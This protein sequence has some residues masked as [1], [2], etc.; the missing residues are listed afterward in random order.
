VAPLNTKTVHWTLV[1]VKRDDEPVTLAQPFARSE[2]SVAVLAIPL[3]MTR[4]LADHYARA[5]WPQRLPRISGELAKMA[6]PAMTVTLVEFVRL[7]A[8]VLPRRRC[9]APL[10]NRARR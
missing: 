8:L 5:S 9:F 6:L 2:R 3:K 1:R 7:S 10:T 4:E